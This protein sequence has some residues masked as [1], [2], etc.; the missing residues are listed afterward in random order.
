MV[1]ACAHHNSHMRR[2]ILV[3]GLVVECTQEAC[4][5]KERKLDFVFYPVKTLPSLISKGT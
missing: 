3:F 5:V 1:T 2:N 4:R